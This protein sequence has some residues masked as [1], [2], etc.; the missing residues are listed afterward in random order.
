MLIPFNRSW[1]RRMPDG[2]V[3][4]EKG[5]FEKFNIKA[6]GILHIG[7]S[8]G[9][10]AE[11]YDQLGVKNVIWIEA[12]P[13]VFEQ[14]RANVTKYNHI[15]IRAC[16]GDRNGEEV[17]FNVSNNEGQSSSFLEFGTHSV[18]HPAVQYVE[19]LKLK[20]VRVDA[21]F[22]AF[23]LDGYNF[24][25]IDLQGCELIALR[26]MTRLLPQ[27]QYVYLEVNRAELYKGCALFD[28]VVVFMS[29]HGFE[30]KIVKWTDHNWGDAFFQRKN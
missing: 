1:R 11:V 9:Q 18:E 13:K 25:N 24:L 2:R 27:F 7:A 29:L 10:E 14:L 4:D 6:T 30:L 20:T 16:I 22:D 21:L 17:V 12:I 26:S 28:E 15:C 3:I 8:T 5:L 23:A 19:K